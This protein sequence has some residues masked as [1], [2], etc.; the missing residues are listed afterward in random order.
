MFKD[1][2]FSWSNASSKISPNVIDI[3]IESNLNITTSNM[4]EEIAIT[5]DR[6][7]GAFGEDTSF[8]LKP[9]EMNSTIYTR[10]Y[11]KF[12][13]FTRTSNYT[14]MNFE[15]KPHNPGINYNVSK[16]AR[17]LCV[18]VFVHNNANFHRLCVKY[19]TRRLLRRLLCLPKRKWAQGCN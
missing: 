3:V 5:I 8:F 14:A 10:D 17:F 6:D 11:L 1:N 9:D 15:L 16:I 12:H 4:S 13:C 2:P 18:Y 19:K 7:P